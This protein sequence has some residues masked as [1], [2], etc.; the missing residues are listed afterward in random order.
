MDAYHPSK[1]PAPGELP[2]EVTFGRN[3]IGFDAEQE[4]RLQVA[5][6]QAVLGQLGYDVGKIDGKYGSKTKAAVKTFQKN[7]KL[8][9]DGKINDNLLKE[10]KIAVKNLPPAESLQTKPAEGQ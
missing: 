9:V 10:L 7:Q 1:P 3:L 8:K 6:A 4:E 2:P 5:K